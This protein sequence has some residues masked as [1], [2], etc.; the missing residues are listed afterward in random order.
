[1]RVLREPHDGHSVV[2]AIVMRLT[3]SDYIYADCCSRIALSGNVN[4]KTAPLPGAPAAQ[5]SPPCCLL[6]DALADSKTDTGP[7]ILI[8]VE[9]PEQPEDSR[10][11]LRI[12]ADPLSLPRNPQ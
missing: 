2:I 11:T 6:H 4:E 8:A 10:G 7:R 5:I 3:L 1:M 9:T 12:K